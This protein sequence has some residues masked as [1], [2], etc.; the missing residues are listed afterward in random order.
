MRWPF[1][2]A[3]HTA[4]ALGRPI[5]GLRP[6]RVYDILGRRAFARPEFKWS[7]N[8]WGHELHLSPYYHIDRNILILGTYDLALHLALERLLKPGMVAL[9]VGANLGEMALHMGA[10][11][12]KEGRVYAFEPAP[13]TYGRLVEHVE[14]NGLGEVV[15]PLAVALSDRTGT[16]E[17]AYPDAATDNQGLASVA[18]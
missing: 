13:P 14:R 3:Y 11:V 5:G 15:T 10:L 17:L 12:G 6:R 9:D 18:N 4:V 16:L 2:I 7:R 8:R 1:R